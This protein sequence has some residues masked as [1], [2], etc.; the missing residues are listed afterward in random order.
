MTNFIDN[1]AFYRT[2]QEEHPD[3]PDI[4]INFVKFMDDGSDSFTDSRFS[5]LPRYNGFVINNQL[6]AARSRGV[7]KLNRTDPVWGKVEIYANYLTHPY[8]LQALIEGVRFS[9]RILNTAGFKENGFVGIKSPAK[10]CENIEFD[11]FEYYQC[12]ARSYTTPIYHIVGMWKMAPESDGG[13]VDARLRVH[14]IGGLRVIDASIMP[15]V[16]RG[17]N[18]APAVMIGEKGS[19]MIKED[20]SN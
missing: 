14:G 11:T 4:N 1:I 2:S 5:L 12:Y 18:H 15:N 6:L 20:W 10:N 8:D 16:T 9:M 7:M 3:L 13:A 17:N 19:D